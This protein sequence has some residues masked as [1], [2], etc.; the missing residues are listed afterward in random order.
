[1]SAKVGGIYKMVDDILERVV[2]VEGGFVDDPLDAGGATRW[3]VTERI[4]RAYGYKGDMRNYPRNE[5]KRVL[6]L[7]CFV[8]PG[9]E[10]LAERC[11]ALAYDMVEI[12]VNLPPGQATRFLQRSLNSLNDPKGH[13]QDPSMLFPN[14]TVDGKCGKGTLSALDKYLKLRGDD[15]I[16]VLL[17]MIN[18]QQ[19]VYYIERTEVRPAAKRFLYG[20][21][22]HRISLK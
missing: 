3:G 18:A 5:A 6:K 13:S 4:A 19:A 17:R 2:G 21:I 20:W 10:P 12:E 16:I 14:L 11:P 9:F 8:E 22:W 15:G 1:M 7:L